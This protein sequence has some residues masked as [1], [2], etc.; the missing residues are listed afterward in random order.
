MS[1]NVLEVTA[2]REHNV[3]ST[4]MLAQISDIVNQRSRLPISIKL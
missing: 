4:E 2:H 1:I 3:V